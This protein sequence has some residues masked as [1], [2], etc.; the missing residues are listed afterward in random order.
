M[1]SRG[2]KGLLVTLIVVSAILTVGPPAAEALDCSDQAG[3]STGSGSINAVAEIDCPG[4]SQ[5]VHQVDADSV[6]GIEVVYDPVCDTSG[7]AVGQ[8]HGQLI[9]GDGGLMYH[10]TAHYSD[11]GERSWDECLTEPPPAAKPG[12]TMAMIRRAFERVPLPQSRVAIQP[13]GGATLVNLETIYST[14]AEGF[15]TEVSL[16]GQRLELRVSP[17]T[18]AWSPGDGSQVM[19]TDWP[20]VPYDPG[21]AKNTYISHTYTNAD[22]VVPVRV[23]TTWSA[24]FRINGHGGFQAVDGTVTMP[25]Q[26]VEVE[27]REAR[28]VLTGG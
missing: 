19:V 4:A 5:T 6:V 16:L 17:A 9:C 15:D 25:G 20:G 28:G 24:Q 2:L 22:G 14:Q 23:D 12:I 1:E 8:C 26:P 7:G 18:Y 27:V 11:G 13:P 3:V 21:L 10:V